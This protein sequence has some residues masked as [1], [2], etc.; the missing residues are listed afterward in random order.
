MA[1]RND[2]A[3]ESFKSTRRTLDTNHRS[4][5]INIHCVVGCMHNE[6][7]SR[8]IALAGATETVAAIRA[9]AAPFFDVL[10]TGDVRRAL[11]W[12][13]AHGDVAAVVADHR[14]TDA[15]GVTLLAAVQQRWPAV[16]RVLLADIEDMAQVIAGLH[17][18]AVQHVMHKPLQ[19]RE[20]LQIIRPGHPRALAS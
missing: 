6:I 19:A 7:R 14:L 1:E 12:L 15:S 16:Q 8:I 17:C 18:G 3:L 10:G 5:S 2:V 9:I 13:K 4:W 20:L 11:G